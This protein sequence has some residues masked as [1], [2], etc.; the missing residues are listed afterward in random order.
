MGRS[1]HVSAALPRGVQR[2]AAAGQLGAF[3][4]LPLTLIT[5]P[6]LIAVAADPEA[7]V[8]ESAARSLMR[9][10]YEPRQ[11]AVV[12]PISTAL[13]SDPAARVRRAAVAAFRSMSQAPRTGPSAGRT[14]GTA[15]R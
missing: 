12:G 3:R 7:D 4:P 13:L 6:P 11:G 15:A 5:P 9:I 8:R 10:G 2:A 14:V 1:L